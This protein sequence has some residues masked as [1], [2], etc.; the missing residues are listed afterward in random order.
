[1]VDDSAILEEGAT[2][3]ADVLLCHALQTQFPSAPLLFS[4]T[5]HSP[6][7]HLIQTY[8]LEIYQV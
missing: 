3:G 6:I 5:L 1:M 2:A 8:H 7:Y 4:S